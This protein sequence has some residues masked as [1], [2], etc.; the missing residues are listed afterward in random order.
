MIKVLLADNDAFSR[1]MYARRFECLHFEVLTADSGDACIRKIR[2]HNPNVI[3]MDVMTSRISRLFF[4]RR[5]RNS[6]MLIGAYRLG[7]AHSSLNRMPSRNASW[8]P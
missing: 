5:S 1:S 2:S 6:A 8:M 7:A 4:S 3:L